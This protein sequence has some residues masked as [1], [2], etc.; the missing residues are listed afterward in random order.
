MKGKSAKMRHLDNDT[1]CMDMYGNTMLACDVIPGQFYYVELDSIQK[2][3]ILEEA[4]IIPHFPSHVAA[5]DTSTYRKF[6]YNARYGRVCVAAA[7]YV[8]NLFKFLAQEQVFFAD[9]QLY[10]NET[11]FAD[12]F[13]GCSFNVHVSTLHQK[14]VVI[15]AQPGTGKSTLIKQIVLRGNRILLVAPGRALVEG[16]VEKLSYLGFVSYKRVAGKPDPWQHANR[17]VSTPD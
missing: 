12:G 14:L 7:K 17:V 16:L 2:E 1:A 3:L 5:L 4:I 11:H 9:E 10:I 8:P 6:L 15:C 13:P